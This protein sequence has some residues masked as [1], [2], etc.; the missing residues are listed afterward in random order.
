M[1]Q[2]KIVITDYIED[3]LDWEVEQMQKRD[4]DFEHYQL[5]LAPE[6]ELVDAIRD[7]DVVIV[8]MAPMPESVISQLEKCRLIIR[9][10]IGY[11][12]VDTDA[13]TK[14]GIRL[15]NIPDY[16]AQEVAEQAVALI[17]ACARRLF[18][19]RAILEESSAT[20]IWDFSELG[21]IHRMHDQTLGVIGAGRIGS[22]VY[23]MTENIFGRRMICDPYMGDRRLAALGVEERYSL[24][25][26]LAEADYVTIHTPL[27]DETRY[28]IDEPQFRIMK[29]SAFLINT[30]R[31]A[32]VNTEALTK[33]VREGWIAGA[34]IDVYE[35][36]PPPAEMELFD[37]PTATLSA[38]LGWNSV[39]A[40]WDIREKIMQDVD[41][42]LAGEPPRFTVNEEVEAKLDGVYREV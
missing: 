5:K 4:I 7:C 13:C 16:C 11:D 6:E 9:H 24:D 42:F 20:G 15:A 12:N 25:D 33:A 30:A 38:H 40:G 32:I 14:Y 19:S 3:N 8:N 21:D 29:E 18:T 39:E 35:T 23:R 37:L 41:L 34:G 36:E 10:G 22:R 26:V 2:A 1:S 31:G 28:M 17:L 27:N